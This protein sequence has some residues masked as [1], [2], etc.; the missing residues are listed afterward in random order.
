M[1]CSTAKFQNVQVVDLD[2]IKIMIKA[3]C[4]T[5]RR[6]PEWINYT[7]FARI[8]SFTGIDQHAV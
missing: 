4:R 2:L 3:G 8:L 1:T 7:F 5:P 6:R